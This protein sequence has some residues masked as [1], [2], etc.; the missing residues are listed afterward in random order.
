M[1]PASGAQATPSAAVG[2]LAFWSAAGEPRVMTAPNP[3]K[4]VLVAVLGALLAAVLAWR[5]AVPVRPAS[6]ELPAFGIG[7]LF[8]VVAAIALH[9]TGP[10]Q[11]LVG[12]LSTTNAGQVLVLL[13]GA[14]I[15]VLFRGAHGAPFVPELASGILGASVGS[16]VRLGLA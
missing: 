16:L 13:L 9:A 10:G 7:L 3:A 4:V 8:A 5:N 11:R 6:L 14:A 2:P 12:F 15:I 1:P